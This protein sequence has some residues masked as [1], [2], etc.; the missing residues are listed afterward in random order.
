M[1]QIVWWTFPILAKALPAYSEYRKVD[2]HAICDLAM[3]NYIEVPVCLRH[4]CAETY[5]DHNFFKY[6]IKTIQILNLLESSFNK[7]CLKFQMRESVNSRLFIMRKK[8]DNLL[9]SIF[10][11]TWIPLY[12]MVGK[13][14]NEIWQL[15]TMV[16]ETSNEIWQLIHS[17]IEFW[18]F[19]GYCRLIMIH[20]WIWNT[21][22]WVI[23]EG[24]LF[25]TSKRLEFL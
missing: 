15:Y 3:Y 5:F 23:L 18:Q 8:L 21:I 25:G 2:D 17:W 7:I 22:F 9:F 13:T 24:F 10:P 4:A 11:N 19:Y 12:T 16:S 6:W 20:N 1:D 14:Y